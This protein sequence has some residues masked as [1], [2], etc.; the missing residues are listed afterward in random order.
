M[1]V[2]WERERYF[3]KFILQN[4]KNTY[5]NIDTRCGAVRYVCVIFL[6]SHKRQHQF[7]LSHSSSRAHTDTHTFST[8]LHSFGSSTWLGFARERRYNK[9]WCNPCGI[10]SNFNKQTYFNIYR[11]Y[12]AIFA[13]A[14]TLPMYWGCFGFVLF[15][16]NKFSFVP[17]PKLPLPENVNKCAFRCLVV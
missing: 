13:N 6:N 16:H 12:F 1:C 4:S 2:L 9:E 11:L 17:I 14:T 15:I 5:L 7:G 8:N 3:P 10:Q